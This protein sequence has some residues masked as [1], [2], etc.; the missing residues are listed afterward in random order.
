MKALQ[1]DQDDNKARRSRRSNEGPTERAVPD[2]DVVAEELPLIPPGRYEAVGGK[3]SVFRIHG[4][5]KLRF[6]FTVL[7]PDEND[8]NGIKRVRLYR[9]YNVRPCPGGR[10]RA[11]AHS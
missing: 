7:V 1:R 4:T 6:E 2:L 9:Y 8:A 11:G 10:L 3:A 5:S